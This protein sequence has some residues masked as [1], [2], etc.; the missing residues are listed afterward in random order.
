LQN[1]LLLEAPHRQSVT[2]LRTSFLPDLDW[3]FLDASVWRPDKHRLQVFNVLVD[4]LGR[5]PV[6]PVYGDVLRVAAVELGPLLAGEH[7]E[8]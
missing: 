7:I 8:V 1:G 5:M 4:P 3:V 6:R 2:R